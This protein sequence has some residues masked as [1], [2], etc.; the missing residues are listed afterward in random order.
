MAIAAT[1]ESPNRIWQRA[2]T[3][4]SA[5]ALFATVITALYWAR[6][7]F[8]PVTLAI[9][10]AFVLSPLVLWLRRLG[11]GKAPTVLAAVGLAGLLVVGTLGIVAWQFSQLVEELPDKT[12]KIKG[13]IASAREA[14]GSGKENR[15]EK[16]F[17]DISAA[18]SPPPP[19]VEAEV[20]P[21]TSTMKVETV[22]KPWTDR[23]TDNLSPVTE[24]L[25]QG[26]FALVLS[27]FIL[28]KRD[29]LR[30][31]LIRL[32]G[33]TRLTTATKAV[34]DASRRI[35]RYLLMQLIINSVFGVLI[36]ITMFA[37]GVNY[38]ILWGVLAS[39]M[40]YIPYLGTWLGLIPAVV[41][42]VAFTD[43][44]WQPATV[45]GVYAALELACNNY[46]EPKLYGSSMGISEVAQLVSAAFWAFLWGPVGLI[47]SGPLTVCLLVLG[48][49]VSGLRFF[50]ILLGD[51]EVLSADLR[52]YQRLAARDQDEAWDIV[53][54]EA[55]AKSALEVV[56]SVLIPSLTNTKR[57]SESG[58]LTLEHSTRMMAMT[59]EISDDLLETAGTESVAPEEAI[60]QTDK[61]RVLI[62]P[63]KDSS[64]EAA[65]GML[66]KLLD[67][68]RWEADV[69]AV[70]QLTSEVVSRAAEFNPA[71]IV[72][73]SLP[74]G[75][76]SHTRYVCKRI[77]RE[78]GKARII[79]CRIAT[80]AYPA[81]SAAEIT[82]AG[83][84]HIAATLADTL[85]YLQT[86]MAA[87]DTQ[88]KVEVKAKESA[89][90][91]MASAKRVTV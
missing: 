37:I 28:W 66:Q 23:L 91:G 56:D 39:L 70:A 62:V 60:A 54:T 26:A 41:V 75:G 85:H 67:P 42:T 45:I 11:L 3:T 27:V 83:A 32:I 12:E 24:I 5:L 1:A 25:G 82:A 59:R 84:T 64:D 58:D 48:K 14:L 88:Q 35:S 80:A 87:L 44:W 6:S 72:I 15:Y 57:D 47:L 43:G 46:F 13:K 63:A 73:C 74:P 40:R 55:K 21:S 69:S 51:E 79:V 33:D 77:A 17:D 9:F 36:T 86:W 90:S 22:Q 10:L 68:R 65:C 30:N 53:R 71:V 20:N 31:R 89:P 50:E 81:D 16:M 19:K 76:L 34:D 2:L 61:V 8:I 49:Y 29:D 18:L 78:V 7:V 52:F 4:L 38:A